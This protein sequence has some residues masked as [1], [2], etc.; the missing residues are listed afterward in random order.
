MR[1][2]GRLR[3]TLCRTAACVP[4]QRGHRVEQ[5]TDTQKPRQALRAFR[6]TGTARWPIRRH[7]RASANLSL[8]NRGL[9]QPPDAGLLVAQLRGRR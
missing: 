8:A 5:I 2:F 3:R 9:R 7:G 6:E 4:W 1:M